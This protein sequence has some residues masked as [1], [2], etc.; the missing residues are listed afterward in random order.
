MSSDRLPREP[1][2][3]HHRPGAAGWPPPPTRGT[4]VINHR[5]L[6]TRSVTGFE[7]AGRP[8]VRESEEQYYSRL[9]QL[10]EEERRRERRHELAR[11][12]HLAR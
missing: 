1:T 12:L 10:A 9:L 5:S 6:I 3:C 2:Y 11:R 8:I 7:H 4:H